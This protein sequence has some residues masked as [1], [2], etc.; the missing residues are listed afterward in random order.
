MKINNIDQL[1]DKIYSLLSLIK[2][3]IHKSNSRH[4][5]KNEVSLSPSKNNQSQYQQSFDYSNRSK[6][7]QSN[8]QANFNRYN[9]QPTNQLTPLSSI[10]NQRYTNR[11]ISAKK[12]KVEY[13]NNLPLNPQPTV[14]RQNSQNNI[15]RRDNASLNK[16]IK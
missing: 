4:K 5:Q 2:K 12:T 8:Y 10:E 3:E 6:D 1:N 15:D 14:L 13:S 16:F 7:I 9:V 11:S